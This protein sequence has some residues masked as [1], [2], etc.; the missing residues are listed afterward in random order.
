[1]Y[2]FFALDKDMKTVKGFTVYEHGE[3]PGLGG[4]VDNPKWKAAWKGKIAFDETG[5]LTLKFPKGKAAPGST[6]IQ[7]GGGNGRWAQSVSPS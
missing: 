7:A 5:K 4:E 6:L 2:G 3:T 1:M